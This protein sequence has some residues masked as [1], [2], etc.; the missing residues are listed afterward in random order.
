MR[1]IKRA[2]LI[3]ATLLLMVAGGWMWTSLAA[4]GVNMT[5][6]AK[7][8]LGTLSEEQ[9][10]VA[11]V[12]F[13]SNERLGWHFIPK[14]QR[15]GLQIKDMKYNQKKAAFKLL[16]SALSE[17]GYDK[18]RQIME[19]EAILH[20]LEKNKDSGQIRDPQRYYV[21]LFGELDE[22]WGLS[23]EGH[24]LSLNFVMDDG[25]IVA[26]TPAFLGANPAE[27]KTDV[28]VGP[29]KG[30]RTLAKEEDLAFQL[31]A[32]FEGPKRDLVII[33]DKAPREMRA[34]GE[35]HAPD[36]APE[37]LPSKEMSESQV[38]TLWALIDSYLENMPPSIA[39]VRRNEIT[40]AGIDKVHF[41]W[42]GAHRPGVGHYYR[43]QG[44]TF[45]IEFVNTQPDAQ[46][47][48]ANHI[49]S[50][51]RNMAGDFHVSR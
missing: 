26:H 15:K 45:L 38:E 39:E 17:V 12:P 37:G 30:T 2:E 36:S 43:V 29:P 9:L 28:G 41:A 40:E 47:N 3:L 31:L 22:R 5:Q 24:H 35:P 13:D 25:R 8:F 49:H 34:A 20:E 11:V 50:V 27:V 7:G 21:T 16:S 51:W 1:A 44:P 32:S 10:E 14:P 4:P 48:P 42:A 46:G 6:A 19:L 18:S 33:A 23:F